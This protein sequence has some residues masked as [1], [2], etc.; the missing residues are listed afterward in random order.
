MAPAVPAPAGG[1]QARLPS[2]CAPFRR[3]G[4]FLSKTGGAGQGSK[5]E[6]AGIFAVFP[7]CSIFVAEPIR[8]FAR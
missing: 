3:S 7:Q 6:R 8:A 5:A 4:R 2:L 1:I